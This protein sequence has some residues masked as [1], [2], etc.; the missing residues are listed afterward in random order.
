MIPIFIILLLGFSFINDK[1]LATQKTIIFIF[2]LF[3]WWFLESF[4]W[5]SGTDFYNYYNN[6]NGLQA[7]D[8][9]ADRFE[10][11]YNLLVIFCRDYLKFTFYIFNSVYYAVIFLL[12]FFSVKKIT[13]HPILFLFIFFCFSVGLMGSSR[14]LMAVSIMFFAS[15]YFLEKKKLIF[16]LCILFASFFHRTIIVCLIFVL[17]NINIKYK[18]WLCIITFAIIIQISGLNMLIMK[19][20]ML[21]LPE[22]FSERFY[23]YLAI[24]SP[25]SID[26]KIYLLGIFRRLLPIVLFF[27]Y[28]NKIREV[29]A[30]N[31]LQYILNILFFSMFAYIMLSF[32]FTFIISRISI[33]FNIFEAL[34][35]VWLISVFIKEKKYGYV[36]GLVLFFLVLCIKSIMYYPQQFL[37]YKTIFFTM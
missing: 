11:G 30:D 14:Q 32:N 23:G 20:M 15:I 13:N 37:P 5:E 33:Y 16:I 35:Y 34:F 4:R 21:L 8:I 29:V 2:C 3:F 12:Y 19:K 6:F 1:L 26:L 24:P 27:I 22:E 25:T 18:Y 28:K 10:L 9:S 17:F 31:I 36:F 7:K